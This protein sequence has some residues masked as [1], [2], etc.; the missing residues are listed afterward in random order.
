MKGRFYKPA[1]WA[2]FAPA[3]LAAHWV[4]VP[5]LPNPSAR[6]SP[7]R[8]GFEKCPKGTSKN[9]LRGR[10]CQFPSWSN[11]SPYTG[12]V[13][14]VCQPRHCQLHPLATVFRSPPKLKLA[15]RR[16][17]SGENGWKCPS[18]LVFYLLG[19][20][21]NLLRGRICQFPSW[22]NSSPYTGHVSRVCQ[23]RHCQLHPLVTVFRS[24][25]FYVLRA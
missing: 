21:K 17:F 18:L 24:S 2:N 22:S 11:S 14:R 23:P 19:T 8:D 1:A 16:M 20:S 25:L 13:S 15:Y 10:I 6:T 5:C 12:H 3:V 7:A 9:L 4:R